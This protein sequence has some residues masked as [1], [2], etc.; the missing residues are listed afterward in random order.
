[1]SENFPYADI[2]FLA[3]VAA[4]IALRL[5]DV[6][7]KKTGHD[8]PLDYSGRSEK[9]PD[10]RG[11]PLPNAEEEDEPYDIRDDLNQLGNPKLLESVEAVRAID[12]SFRLGQFQEGAKAAFE[13]ILNAYRE[14][15]K[16]T[17]K[18][19][20]SKA[21]YRKFSEQIDRREM[22][23][24]HEETTLVAILQAEVESIALESSSR[25]RIT[26]AYK[27]EQVLVVRDSKGEIIEGDP[28]DVE[29]VEDHWVFERNL[30][31][32]DPNWALVSV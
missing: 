27:S 20:L 23:G 16:E 22:T 1:M 24:R 15:D 3:V 4:F 19:L 32:Q 29:E 6:L 5:R 31:S 30:R 26:V 11:V 2:V 7:G 10:E 18:S 25:C 9:R 28:S 8:T 21:I 14:G 12:P 17:L 13:M